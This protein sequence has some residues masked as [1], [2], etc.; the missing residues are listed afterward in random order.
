MASATI[1]P[2][3]IA[4]YDIHVY[5]DHTNV[6]QTQIAQQF[7]AHIAKTFPNLRLF[8]LCRGPVGPHATGMFQGIIGTPEE[9]G[10]VVPWLTL[11]RRGLSILLHPHTGDD[12]A[13][14]SIYAIWIGEQM[15][16][17]LDVLRR[18]H[19]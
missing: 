10:V 1:F 16:I 15:P 14:H 11:N 2:S 8:G 19:H 6:D 17:N 5:F 9:F 7:H 13:D 18:L 12:V 4:A 3:P